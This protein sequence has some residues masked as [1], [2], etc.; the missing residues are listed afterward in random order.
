MQ[1]DEEMT[2]KWHLFKFIQL[3]WRC[4]R[5]HSSPFGPKRRMRPKRLTTVGRKGRT[6]CQ[7]LYKLINLN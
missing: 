4:K 3:E 6:A 5:G 1:H 7:L 2:R